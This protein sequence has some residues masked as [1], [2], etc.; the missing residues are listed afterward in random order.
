[1]CFDNKCNGMQTLYFFVPKLPT[2][3]HGKIFKNNLALTWDKLPMFPQGKISKK[4][5]AL[6]WD[7]VQSPNFFIR[8]FLGS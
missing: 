1:M 5:L 2:F 6:T 7:I 4:N 3:P 8:L